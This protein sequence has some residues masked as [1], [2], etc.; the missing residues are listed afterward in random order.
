MVKKALYIDGYNTGTAPEAI[1]GKYLRRNYLNGAWGWEDGIKLAHETISPSYGQVEFYLENVPL[2]G[3]NVQMW[4]NGLKQD[5]FDFSYLDG[6]VE[7]TG[8]L[9]INATDSVEFYYQYLIEQ[10]IP[11]TLGAALW[12]EWDDNDWF[13]DTILDTSVIPN[14]FITVY[15]R[16]LYGGK[17]NSS[18]GKRFDVGTFSSRRIA[19]LTPGDYSIHDA[20]ASVWSAFHQE[21]SGYY[22]C[23][24]NFGLTLTRLY[25][26]CPNN[27]DI[28]T[29]MRIN[30][31]NGRILWYIQN[32]GGVD[33]L[34]VSTGNNAIT[35]GAVNVIGI[36]FS[37]AFGYE[38][39]VDGGIVASGAL[40]GIPP[41]GAPYSSLAIAS[42]GS[43]TFN[44]DLFDVV[45]FDRVLS[46]YEQNLVIAWLQ[47]RWSP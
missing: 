6:Y 28:G 37:F 17:F 31:S 2:D 40:P 13:Y 5:T 4:I 29:Y 8:S 26:T 35:I 18:V 41:A 1:V 19:T 9:I 45:G 39:T 12:V 3:Y 46:D 25:V 20:P 22:V 34:S 11:V 27:T 14:E 7:Y 33:W 24:P 47:D 30:H 44:G 16:G 38:I 32:G 21:W 23:V 15:N 42:Y 10:S 36:R 43:T